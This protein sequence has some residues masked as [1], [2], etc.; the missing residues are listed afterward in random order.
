MNDL[1]DD[2][3][4][5]QLVLNAIHTVPNT[6]GEAAIRLNEMYST[7]GIIDTISIL[8]NGWIQL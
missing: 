6:S 5:V 2:E 3:A 7:L 4:A 8:R 1:Q